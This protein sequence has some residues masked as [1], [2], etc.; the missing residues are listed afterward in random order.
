MPPAESDAPTAA[1]PAPPSYAA[2]QPTYAAPPVQPGYAPAWPAPAAPSRFNRRLVMPAALT[3]VVVTIGAVVIA[4]FGLGNG[5][6][7]LSNAQMLAALHTAS[8]GLT[9]SP[10]TRFGM[11]ITIS[12]DGHQQTMTM[13]GFTTDKHEGS[14]TMTGA[15][16]DESMVLVNGTLYMKLPAIATSLSYG[17]PWLGVKA[18]TPDAGQQQ[19]DSSGP[20]GL[21]GGLSEFAGTVHDHGTQTVDGVATTEYSVDIDVN[22]LISKV[23]PQLTSSS[24]FA[25]LGSLGISDIPM[26][27]WID[28]AGLPRKM[29][30][31]MSFHGVSMSEIATF[32]PTDDVP[33][34]TA[35]P[36]SQVYLFNSFTDF[37]ANLERLTGGV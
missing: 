16:I 18:P 17:K 12:K 32:T 3:A 7:S 33:S 21:L 34:I 26:T 5:G 6:S 27:I 2:P 20:G 4:M 1:P 37:N 25:N 10:A 11:T 30:L 23:A 22:K 15:G 9:R 29:S 14:F 8:T 36:A 28:R 19:F 13:S 35:P 31:D 24:A